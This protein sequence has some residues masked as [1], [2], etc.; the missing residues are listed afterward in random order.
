LQNARELTQQKPRQAIKMARTETNRL[1]K[2]N[3]QQTKK[4]KTVAKMLLS[5]NV[6]RFGPNK[7][8][9][10]AAQGVSE[11]KKMAGLK[12]I[13]SRRRTLFRFQFAIKTATTVAGAAANEI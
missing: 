12:Q 6:F 7:N 1:P 2:P 13:F 9:D 11:W 8:C 3:Y 4:H 10:K 5:A